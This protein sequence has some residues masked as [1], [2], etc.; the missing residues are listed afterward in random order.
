[1]TTIWNTE[2]MRTTLDRY[3]QEFIEAIEKGDLNL[4]D[5]IQQKSKAISDYI[6]ELSVSAVTPTPQK[7]IEKVAKERQTKGRK[8]YLESDLI[9][10]CDPIALSFDYAAFKMNKD[11]RTPAESVKFLQIGKLPDRRNGAKPSDTLIALVAMET[12]QDL[13]EGKIYG[14]KRLGSNLTLGN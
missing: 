10:K 8:I 9:S 6:A 2:Q 12:K 13:I 3:A 5:A 14:F 7:I 11:E 4:A 1:M